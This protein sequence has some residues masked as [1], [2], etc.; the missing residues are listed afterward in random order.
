M[1]L[2]GLRV[3]LRGLLLPPGGPLLIGIAGLLIW[4]RRARLGI[5]LCTVSIASLWLL[6]TPLVADHIAIAAQ[7][8]PAID[9]AHLAALRDR[10]GAIVVL[11]GGFRRN[12]PETGADAPSP[13]A[14][15]RL[16]E[17]ARVARATRLPVLVSGSRRETAA[18]KRFMEESLGVPVRW[19][20]DQS[21]TTRENAQFSARMLKPLGIDRVVL[22]TTGTHMT[23][24]AGDFSAAGFT[25]IAAP[26]GMVTRDEI[27]VLGFVPS[28]EA[29]SRSQTALYEWAGRF[30]H[31]FV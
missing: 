15:L 3:V 31:Q 21:S 10:A 2:F 30:V 9:P 28:P 25:V 14:D 7:G 17:A 27:G 16:I 19:V 24:A 12:A 26:A 6:S 11:G 20:E 23:R 22:V 29:L 4:R 13:A 8:Y 5:A 18:M 1:I